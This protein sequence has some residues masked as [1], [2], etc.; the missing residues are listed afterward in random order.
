MGFSG[1]FRD[2]ILSS[3]L[4]NKRNKRDERNH[5]PLSL[6]YLFTHSL[7]HSLTCSLF[8]FLYLQRS[9]WHRI[10]PGRPTRCLRTPRSWTA[11]RPAGGIPRSSAPS[12]ASRPRLGSWLSPLRSTNPRPSRLR[13]TEQ[14]RGLNMVFQVRM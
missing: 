13:Y 2:Y 9:K 14:T 11:L 7:T 1:I 3:M 10:R 5:C 4:N 12:P 6:T 8:I